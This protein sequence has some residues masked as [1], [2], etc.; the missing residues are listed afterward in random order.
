MTRSPLLP[1]LVA[2]LGAASLGGCPKGG[3]NKKTTEPVTKRDAGSGHTLAP[4]DTRASELPPA[5]PLPPVPR[6][7]PPLPAVRGITPEAVAL[8]ELLFHDTRLSSSGTLGCATCHDPTRGYAGEIQATA[9]GQPNLRRTPA[10]V[11]L[12]WA[13][14]LGWDGRYG[15]ADSFLAVH[16]RGQ[17]GDDLGDSLPRIANLPMYRL[18][19]ARVSAQLAADDPSMAMATT[20]PVNATAAR[21]ALSAFVLT[22]YAGDSP[23]DRI[24]SSARKPEPGVAP[25]PLL[26]GYLLFAGKAQCGLCHTPP[27]YTDGGYHAVTVGKANDPGRGF[28]EKKKTGSFRTP[29]LRGAAS[30]GRFFHTGEATS[31]EQVV[32]SYIALANAETR[33]PALYDP[34]ISKIRISSE[35]RGQLLVFL[36]ALSATTPP[37]AKPALP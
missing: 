7:L 22:R 28:V 21:R 16:V 3:D 34:L 35:E 33:G 29:T 26:A 24:E 10:L 14:E 36:R 27:L 1:I 30:R 13:P 12:A 6:G 11:N 20:D 17:L 9:A 31:L 19:F 23:W 18:H 15:S 5:P 37:P 25:D 32:D 2:A 8:G 4:D